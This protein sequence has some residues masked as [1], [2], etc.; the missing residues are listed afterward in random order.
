[1]MGKRK[2]RTAEEPAVDVAGKCEF[3]RRESS[4]FKW[5]ESA[6]T[7]WRERVGFIWRESARFVW[8]VSER[9]KSRESRGFVW[10]KGKRQIRVAQSMSFISTKSKV[11]WLRESPSF[12]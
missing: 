2:L 7:L 8:W 6:R 10:Q 1:M 11:A 3:K 9:P 12:T 5:R 4:T